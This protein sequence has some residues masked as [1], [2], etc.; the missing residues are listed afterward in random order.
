MQFSTSVKKVEFCGSSYLLA[1]SDDQQVQITDL[2]SQK[3]VCLPA[4]SKH[5]K[6]IVDACISPDQQLL[7][8]LS[9]EG[10]LVLV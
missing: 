1:H 4:E 7:A 3:P 5:P 8:T 6:P 2:D 10:L 9:A